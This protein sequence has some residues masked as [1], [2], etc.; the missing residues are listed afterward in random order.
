[1]PRP[2]KCRRVGL[3]PANPCF[4][5]QMGNPDEVVLNVEEIEAIR[6]SDLLGMDQDAA[7]ESMDVSRGTFQRIINE[8]RRKLA[9]ALINGKT[10]RIKGGNYCLIEQ[11]PCC[12]EQG[13]I[14]RGRRCSRPDRC[15]GGV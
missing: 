4:Y 3:V 9:D 1:M 11:R 15:E 7:A 14:C 5:P 10:I 8:A 6:L 13:R 2:R 12:K